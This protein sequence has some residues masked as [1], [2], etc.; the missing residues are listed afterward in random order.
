MYK[1]GILKMLFFKTIIFLA[2]HFLA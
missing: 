2:K 1:C